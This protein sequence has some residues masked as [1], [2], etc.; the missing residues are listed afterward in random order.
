MWSISFILGVLSACAAAHFATD[1][2]HQGHGEGKGGH[3]GDVGNGDSLI[4]HSGPKTYKIPGVLVGG[5]LTQYG[6]NVTTYPDDGEDPQAFSDSL[7]G[8]CPNLPG[9]NFNY[10]GDN[11]ALQIST[12]IEVYNETNYVLLASSETSRPNHHGDFKYPKF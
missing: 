6:L 7:G 12:L 4:F 2:H 11:A 1:H 10:S 5:N 3:S 8:F 9:C